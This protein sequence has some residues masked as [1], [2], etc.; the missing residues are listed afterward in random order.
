MPKRVVP[1]KQTLSSLAEKHRDEGFFVA[2]IF[3][4]AENPNP[5]PAWHRL[6]TQKHPQSLPAKP[7]GMEYEL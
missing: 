7:G 3:D 4:P 2:L 5:P 6:T 1:R